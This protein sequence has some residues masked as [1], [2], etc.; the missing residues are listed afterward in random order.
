[1]SNVQQINSASARPIS[2]YNTKH[3]QIP[4]IA[5]LQASP[6]PEQTIRTFNNAF[7]TPTNHL[8]VNGQY[9]RTGLIS[10]FD[11]RKLTGFQR[12]YLFAK[13]FFFIKKQTLNIHA[14]W[15]HDSWSNNYFHWF[16]DTLPRLFLLNTQIEHAV[17]VLPVELSKSTFIVESLELLGIEH[18]WIDQK[19]SHRF[20]SLSVVHTSTLLPDINPLLQMQ[21]REALFLALEIN[22]QE[23]PFRKIYISR[24]HARYRKIINENELVSAL[25]K[26]A[27]EII[28]PEKLSFKEQVKLFAESKALISIHGAGHTNCMFMKK[29]AKVMEIRNM[30]W[31]SQPLCFWG[32]ANIF[33]L[34]WEYVTATRVNEISN[35]ND[36]FLT[37]HIFEESLSAFE[38]IE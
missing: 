2:P 1:M 23:K 14:L 31:Y 6:L 16:N 30:E 22:P 21:M 25:T 11:S 10:G 19:K 38:H 8:F 5:L 29:G 32:L 33:E 27:Y 9:I 7:L 35:F 28:Y 18:E 20:D 17:A 24:E 36:V 37:P 12:F 13:S 4:A 34:K 26:Y 15:A 3:L